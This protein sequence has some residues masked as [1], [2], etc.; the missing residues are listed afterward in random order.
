MTPTP[1]DVTEIDVDVF[2]PF[3]GALL[4]MYSQSNHRVLHAYLG[5]VIEVSL[6]L[7]E[8]A[9]RAWPQDDPRLTAFSNYPQLGS[10][11]AR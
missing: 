8:R 10:A 9:G 5:P 6:V 2:A 11:M 7:L 3:V 1:A 4:D